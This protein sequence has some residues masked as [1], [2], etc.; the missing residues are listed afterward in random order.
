MPSWKMKLKM[1]Q[2]M[3]RRVGKKTGKNM[4]KLLL[5]SLIQFLV[6]FLLLVLMYYY[7][8]RGGS[9]GSIIVEILIKVPLVVIAGILIGDFDLYKRAKFS[10]LAVA[11]SAVL[12]ICGIMVSLFIA[13]LL[14]GFMGFILCLLV[15]E[16]PAII[17]YNL[18]SHQIRK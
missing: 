9:K 4:K 11:V 6:S 8:I 3:C 2:Q 5:K 14:K 7:W 16:V 13:D 12:C 15:I 1:T 18:I 17:G 10:F